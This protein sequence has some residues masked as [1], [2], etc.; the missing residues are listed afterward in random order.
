M[1][2]FEEAVGEYFGAKL[3]DV[4]GPDDGTCVLFALL[5]LLPPLDD[6]LLLCAFVLLVGLEVGKLGT[7]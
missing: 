1:V 5:L 2:G 6:L 7:V 4:V 3:F